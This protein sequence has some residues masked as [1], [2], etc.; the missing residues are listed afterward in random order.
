MAEETRVW[1]EA[2]KDAFTSRGNVLVSAAAGSGKTATL[3]E[4]IMYLLKNVGGAKLS[5]FLI[6]T[7][8][9]AAASELA[10]KIGQRIAK[11]AKSDK[12]MLRHLNGVAAADICTIHSFCLK[13]IRE[14]CT[15]LG[16]PPELSIIETSDAELLAD[17][18]MAEAVDDVFGGEVSLDGEGLCGITEL[19]DNIGSASSSDRLDEGL[20]ELRRKLV[21]VGLDERFLE[22]CADELD[23]ASHGSFFE[24]KWG[25]AITDECMETVDALASELSAARKEIAESEVLDEKYGPMANGL[26]AFLGG[27][28]DALESGEREKIDAAFSAVPDLDMRRI[29]VKAEAQNDGSLLFKDVLR[30]Q[31]PA[32]TESLHTRFFSVS[33]EANSECLALEA[34]I[35]RSSA[36]ILREF[37]KKYDK[38]KRDRGLLDYQDIEDLALKLLIDENGEPTEAARNAAGTHRFIFIDEFQDTNSTQ[39][40][41]FRAVS[42]DAELF[43]VGDVKQSIYRFRGAEP[44]VFAGYREAWSADGSPASDRFPAG[45]SIFMSDNFRCSAPI[46]DFVNSVS[47]ATFPYTAVPFEKK[48][49]LAWGGIE[50]SEE[51]V[52]LCLLGGDRDDGLE[53]VDEPGYVARRI[54]GMTK[55]GKYKYSDFAI[56]LR[57]ANVSARDYETALRELGI[58]VNRE[59]GT[60]LAS[61]SEVKFFLSV[62]RAIDNPMRDASLAGAMMSGAFGFTLDELTQ[63]RLAGKDCPL[64]VSVCRFAD[65][66]GELSEKCAAFR[67]KLAV[68]RQTERGMSADRFIEYLFSE[69]DVFSC[70]EV[71]SKTHGKENLLTIHELARSYETGVFGGLYGFID[72]IEGKLESDELKSA[73][74]DSGGG[75]TIT[76]IHSSKGLEFPVCFVSKTNSRR[77]TRDEKDEFLIDRELGVGTYLSDPAG[78]FRCGNPVREVLKSKIS[79]LGAEEE[80]RVLY[81]ALTRAKKKLIVTASYPTLKK[82]GPETKIEEAKLKKALTNGYTVRNTDTY[83][84]HILRAYVTEEGICEL[85]NVGAMT[86]DEVCGAS[87]AGTAA[88]TE[89]AEA[90]DGAAALVKERI[91]FK[92]PGS[93]RS[94]IPSKVSVSKLYPELL[95]DEGE[96]APVM[97]VLEESFGEEPET[98]EMPRPRF[99]TGTVDYS[100]AERGTSTHAFMQ[101]ADFD[102]L[103]QNGAAAEIGRLTEKGF[104]TPRMAS[105]VEKAQIERFAGSALMD[106]IKKARRVVR[107]FRFNMAFPAANF[108]SDAELRRLLAEAGETV[109][110]Q[111]V[112]DLVFE[113]ENG[114]LVLVDYKT[115]AMNAYELSH[116]EAGHR[117]LRERHSRQLS[118][119]AEAVRRIFGRSPDEVYV[120]S[121]PLG[122]TVTI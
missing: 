42:G 86:A 96:E 91:D 1:T 32:Q 58:S 88:S 50:K 31:I 114:S 13:L 70:G 73:G 106:R 8:T 35:L 103:S 37:T 81:V 97:Y 90:D 22:K 3:S 43:F 75:V 98:E 46:I 16:L 21:S 120:Y 109:T 5:D 62:L 83:I 47:R 60:S 17:R 84:E 119:Y 78:F 112:F 29:R 44:E 49:E 14:N 36:V 59:G 40:S 99:M 102:L 121:M 4:K 94:R 89:T 56:L 51:K 122:E 74:A 52:E 20:R 118:Y 25:R 26:F 95:D 72:Y 10:D 111:G 65:G 11:E 69:L 108:T 6:V 87:A 63:I 68:L 38:A 71:A 45:R 30:R 93:Y 7:Y 15:A 79:R 92:Y 12:S 85:L 18:A 28:K 105:L 76:S 33:D 34:R 9:R 2:Q 77:N 53:P 110:V 82:S 19:S 107:E 64:Y 104:I 115:D 116:P 67:D 41:I 27:I 23:E 66:E 113:D 61:E 48:D 39:D 57:S 55:N 117:K 80:M 101:F 24:T 100:P 54:L